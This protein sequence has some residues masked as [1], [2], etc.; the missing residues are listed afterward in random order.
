MV[1][2]GSGKSARPG[3]IYVLYT[4]WVKICYNDAVWPKAL[5]IRSW[6]GNAAVGMEHEAER[7]A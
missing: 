3:A 1:D 7:V 6:P 4:N 5:H 2:F